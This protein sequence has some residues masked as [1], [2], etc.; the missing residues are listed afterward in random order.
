MKNYY[1]MPL[2][3]TFSEEDYKRILNK[4]PSELL[5]YGVTGITQATYLYDLLKNREGLT[6]VSDGH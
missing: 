2:K 6:V 1:F 5:K 3:I 4:G